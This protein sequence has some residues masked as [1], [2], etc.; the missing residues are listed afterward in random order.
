MSRVKNITVATRI[1][2]VIMLVAV[3]AL[4]GTLIYGAIVRDD[5]TR[6]AIEGR[7]VASGAAKAD[8]LSR[9]LNS[10]E[11][12]VLQMASSAMTV[13]AAQRFSATYKELP[14]IDTLG[15]EQTETLLSFYRDEFIPGLEV[16]RGRAVSLRSVVP[17]TDSAA[18][19]QATYFAAAEETELDAALI[20]DAGDGSSWSE[21]H[22]ELHPLL[23]DTAITFGFNDVFIIDPQTSAVVYTAAKKT[24]FGTSMEVGPIAGSAVTS[25]LESILRNPIEGTVTVAD[26]S[27]YD[28]DSAAPRAFAG[29]PI[30]DGDRLVG[31]LMVKIA[32]DE[33]SRITTQD[34]DWTAMR[35]GD[36]GEIF[37]VGADGLMR[38]DSRMFLEQPDDYF[39]SAMEAGT[40]DSQDV[41]GVKSAETTV[42][43]QRMGPSTLDA[44]EQSNDEIV[45]STNYLGG[46]VLMA[47]LSI[48]NPFGDWTLVFQ[49]G[50]EEALDSSNAA[51]IASSISVAMFVLILT[52][53]ASTWAE[54]FMRPVRVLSMRLHA[55]AGGTQDT[56]DTAR[57]D[58]ERTRTTKE[59]TELTDTIDVMLESLR[60]REETA[61]A[62][63][64]ERREIVRQFLPEDVANRVESGDRSIE[65]VKKATVVSVVIGGIGRLG[66][67]DAGDVARDTV[68]QMIE[69]LDATARDHGLRRVKV[70][71]D[72][73]VAVCG[74]DTPHVDHIARSIRVAVAA[75]QP[76]ADVSQDTNA[77]DTSV[78]IATGPV[79]AG[80]AGSD[81]LM[82]DAWGPTVAEAGRLARLAP[83]GAVLISESVVRQ[84]PADISVTEGTDAST[85][86][87]TWSIDLDST[88]AESRP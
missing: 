30:F 73:W 88:E 9:Y 11:S 51:R 79:S 39:D 82:Y 64:S 18:Y 15:E 8:E 56:V 29:S 69:E 81:H 74:L 85:S 23:R 5:L 72:A 31:V 60:E 13:D 70:V 59:F 66:D 76:N 10:I 84:L 38:S 16:S 57:L 35:L 47:A 7:A 50:T 21:V 86:R 33:I 65:H 24:D 46:D 87:V 1:A 14:G 45:D 41:D 67:N 12:S 77:G 37:V 62:L 19:L 71:G 2:V 53:V 52:F 26:F 20:E 49:V 42:M 27:R 78:G 80:L 44:I 4:G 32:P 58:T 6:A 25:I 43:F 75:V 83:A 40:L 63:E 28:P 22:G 68:E 36:T 54:A 48:E 17:A 61:V 3:G 55:L 34:A